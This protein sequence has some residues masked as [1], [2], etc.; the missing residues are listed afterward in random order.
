[1]ERK[2]RGEETAARGEKID[3][4]HPIIEKID[5]RRLGSLSIVLNYSRRRWISIAFFG[6]SYFSDN[7][8]LSL[9]RIIAC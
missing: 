6:E 7:K 2:R 5:D 9:A 4:Q 1:M 3:L 8:L